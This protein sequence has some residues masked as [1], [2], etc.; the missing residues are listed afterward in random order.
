MRLE[1]SPGAVAKSQ[2]VIKPPPV[3]RDTELAPYDNVTPHPGAGP[4][5]VG[6]AL[7]ANLMISPTFMHR[8]TQ[9]NA[10]AVGHARTVGWPRKQPV[11]QDWV[12]RRRN[13]RVRL[14]SLGKRRDDHSCL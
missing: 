9:F 6:A 1:S 8:M 7:P 12:S 14:G 11:R 2:S 3:E 10:V 4:A 5:M 13:R